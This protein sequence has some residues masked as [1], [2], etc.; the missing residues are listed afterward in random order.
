MTTKTVPDQVID[1]KGFCLRALHPSDADDIEVAC[2]DV[3]TQRWLPLPQPYTVE[4]ARSFIMEQ[5]VSQRD[6]GSGAVFAIDV[7]GRLHGCIDLKKTDWC[8]GTS[9]IG[10]WV[11]PWGRGAGLAGRAA[12]TLARWALVELGLQRV[13]VRVAGDNVASQR[14]AE[15]AGFCREAFFAAPVTR[16]AGRSTSSCT[17]SSVETSTWGQVRR[18]SRMRKAFADDNR[19]QRRPQCC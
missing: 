4:T 15:A 7:E 10:Y 9:E 18:T 14:T 12:A 11:A 3:L 6:S 1:G 5:A 8:A 13:E 16:T 17:R 19:V 2:S